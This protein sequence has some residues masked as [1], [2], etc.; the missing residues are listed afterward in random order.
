MGVPVGAW[1]TSGGTRGRLVGAPVG[2]PKVDQSIARDAY[3]SSLQFVTVALFV[4]VAVTATAAAAI[5]F[6]IPERSALASKERSRCFAQRAAQPTVI[7]SAWNA[8]HALPGADSTTCS[9]GSSSHTS[10]PKRQA[11]SLLGLPPTTM[12]S[13]SDHN[14]SQDNAT[15]LTTI[16]NTD[17]EAHRLLAM[18]VVSATAVSECLSAS[19]PPHPPP[20]LA[21]PAIGVSECL[22]AS[23]SPHPP[24]T[25]A[26]SA[27]G[28]SEYLSSRTSPPH[29]PSAAVGSASFCGIQNRWS[30]IPKRGLGPTPLT[31]KPAS[32]PSI[33]D[34]KRSNNTR[35]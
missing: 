9:W 10:Y 34:T 16:A 17:K 15:P 26:A 28:V 6:L 27:I 3:Q 13:W 30:S 7:T 25:L 19:P 32:Q 23:P 8:E 12:P 35:N 11:I 31:C 5:L 20:T 29:A 1:S 22:S 24:P 18:H 21:A 33:R 2:A 4:T 14:D